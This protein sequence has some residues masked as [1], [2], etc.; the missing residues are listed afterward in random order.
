MQ[1]AAPTRAGSDSVL[2]GVKQAYNARASVSKLEQQDLAVVRNMLEGLTREVEG[3]MR[4]FNAE[5]SS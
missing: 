2:M 4:K 1:A 3:A 5:K